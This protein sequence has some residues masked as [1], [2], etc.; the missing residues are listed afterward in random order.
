MAHCTTFLEDLGSKPSL[1]PDEKKQNKSNGSYSWLVSVGA[2][3][4][5]YYFIRLSRFRSEKK[6]FCS[7][8]LTTSLLR[9]VGTGTFPFTRAS[10]GSATAQSPLMIGRNEGDLAGL[11]RIP[12]PFRTNVLDVLLVVDYVLSDSRNFS[13]T[14]VET[15]TLQIQATARCLTSAGTTGL[16]ETLRFPPGSAAVRPCDFD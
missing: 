3:F 5:Y 14:K 13:D 9:V 16:C 6:H 8:A 4:F 2:I 1:R 7:V 11:G 10:P 15:F 12:A